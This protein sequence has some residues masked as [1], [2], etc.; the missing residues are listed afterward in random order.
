MNNAIGLFVMYFSLVQFAEAAIYAGC[1]TTFWDRALVILLGSQLAVY[2]LVTQKDTS[3]AHYPYMTA[4][5]LLVAA[6]STVTPLRDRTSESCVEYLYDDKMAQLLFFQ[7]LTIFFST[8][9]QP[10]YRCTGY[11]LGV[12]G[13]LSFIS[14]DYANASLWCWSSAVAAPL[15]WGLCT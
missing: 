7:Y 4:L 15:M 2:T 12:T 8:I 5:G 13:F 1:D 9:V 10:E 6:Y 3:P 11:T 14:R